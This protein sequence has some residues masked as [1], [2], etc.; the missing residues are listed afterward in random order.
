MLLLLSLCYYSYSCVVSASGCSLVLLL[1]LLLLL[2]AVL[3]RIYKGES[4]GR[5]EVC[6]NLTPMPLPGSTRI[7]PGNTGCH[8]ARTRDRN[9]RGP[10]N[11]AGHE[12]VRQLSKQV[13]CTGVY[14]V[15]QS[16]RGT[17]PCVFV[18]GCASSGLGAMALVHSEGFQQQTG[19]R[20][21]W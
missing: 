16:C 7:G 9:S 6:R 10:I 11:R 19:S 20:W 12:A 13:V 3:L 15:A 18:E 14:V 8:E 5:R 1:R 21:V 17:P 4:G 2:H